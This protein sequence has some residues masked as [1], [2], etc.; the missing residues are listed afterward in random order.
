MKDNGIVYGSKAQAIPIVVGKNTVYEHSDIRQI[1][2]EFG[3]RIYQYHEKQYTK[4]EWLGRLT[5]RTEET[6]AINGKA[7]TPKKVYMERD[8]VLYGDSFARCLHTNRGIEP[9]NKVYWELLTV[10][11]MILELMERV[12]ALEQ[13]E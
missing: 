2:N 6:K 8:T 7:W 12:S 13:E 9:T 3:D 1:V 5:E 4:E 11:D 10:S